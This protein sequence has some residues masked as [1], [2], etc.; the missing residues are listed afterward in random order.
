[1]ITKE[2]LREIDFFSRDE[3]EYFGDN[4]QYMFNIKSQELWNFNDGFGEPD[5]LCK[6]TDF[7]KLKELITLNVR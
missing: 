7:E 5:L 3:T 6:V 4:W 2:N 1:M